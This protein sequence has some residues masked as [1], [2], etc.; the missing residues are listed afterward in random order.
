VRKEADRR[1]HET[2]RG[3]L[4]GDDLLRPRLRGTVHHDDLEVAEGPSTP[5]SLRGKAWNY[6]ALLKDGRGDAR[7]FYEAVERAI[8]VSDDV[9][10]RENLACRLIDDGR[11]A[12]AVP[13]LERLVTEDPTRIRSIYHLARARHVS[14]VLPRKR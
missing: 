3:K 7:G 12:E 6:L 8:A 13:L 14:M 2:D 5:R 11:G 10:A 4:R 9:D 1:L